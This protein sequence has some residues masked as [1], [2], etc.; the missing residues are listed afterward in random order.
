MAHR[1]R[2]NRGFEKTIEDVRWAGASHVF[3]AQGAGSV[4]QVMVTDGAKETIMRI[5]GEIVSFI[6]GFVAPATL[7]EIGLG[8]LVVQ[9]GSG[10]TIIQK[11]LTDADA[12]WLFYERWVIGH[13]EAAV[14]SVGVPGISSFRKT[15]DSKAMRILREGREVQLVLESITLGDSVAV[16]TH[17]G[18]RMLLGTH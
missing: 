7:T 8:A 9:A 5:R 15:I 10:T 11:P 3:L 16:N 17:F 13:E 6:D 18:F 4:A 12:P 2:S 14:D 1:R